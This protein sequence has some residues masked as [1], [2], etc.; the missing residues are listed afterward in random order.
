MA[1][2]LEVELMMQQQLLADR[3]RVLPP[4]D[5]VIAQTR[6][7]VAF[8]MAAVDRNGEALELLER[9]GAEELAM[10]G[11]DH[12][13]TL[14]TRA[15]IARQLM[16]LGRFNEA[17]GQLG[18]LIGDSTRLLGAFS[19]A[20]LAVHHSYVRCLRGMGRPERA[21]AHLRGLCP[22]AIAVLGPEQIDTI[23]IRAEFVAALVE[24]GEEDE[25]LQEL[26]VLHYCC[27]T[28]EPGSPLRD[29]IESTLT[30]LLGVE[31]DDSEDDD[32]EDADT[33]DE[34]RENREDGDVDQ[35]GLPFAA[36]QRTLNGP[37]D[38]EPGDLVFVALTDILP[39]VVMIA[40]VEA[41]GYLSDAPYAE[42]ERL[43]EA[44]R[45]V[46]DDDDN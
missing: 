28:L 16:K 19:A 26:W 29:W 25:T 42:V 35:D 2:R 8:C 36:N 23:A 43:R 21:V 5:L 7:N 46:S 14:V 45:A 12:P 3:E 33:G 22:A 11:P 24:I 30:E 1:G 40:T 6:H 41:D 20:T 38:G 44:Y 34:G 17:I 10:F 9:C 37:P 15:E 31:D 18:T 4:G 32:T 13:A 39:P 27:S